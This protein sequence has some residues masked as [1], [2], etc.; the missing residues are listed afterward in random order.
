MLPRTVVSEH[1][2]H[3]GSRSGSARSSSGSSLLSLGFGVLKRG[4]WQAV[5]PYFLC[6]VSAGHPA[7]PPAR[8]GDVKVYEHDEHHEHWASGMR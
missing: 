7:C 1:R 8:Q 2:A 6:L 4:G 5:R 3:P